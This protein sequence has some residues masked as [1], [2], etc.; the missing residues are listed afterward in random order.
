MQFITV[1]A[2]AVAVVR[3]AAALVPH[4]PVSLGA[5]SALM[6]REPP[7][8]KARET[9]NS[10]VAM[11][12][13]VSNTTGMDAGAWNGT[14]YVPPNVDVS[15]IPM[16]RE[17]V[18]EDSREEVQTQTVHAGSVRCVFTVGA[19]VATMMSMLRGSL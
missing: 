2:L 4:G 14:H 11:M 12:L 17:D 7:K 9:A 19:A 8:L 3:E 6:P 16:D 13:N 15:D 5:G 18:L 10:M 1:V